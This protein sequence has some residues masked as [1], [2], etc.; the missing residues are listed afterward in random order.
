MPVCDIEVTFVVGG[1]LNPTPTQ[2]PLTSV[3]LP[4]VVEVRDVRAVV[5]LR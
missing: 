5:G 3:A 2:P 4:D 1:G